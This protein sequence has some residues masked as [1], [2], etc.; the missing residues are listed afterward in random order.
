MLKFLFCDFISVPI[1]KLTNC[2]FFLSFCTSVCCFLSLAVPHI[3]HLGLHRLMPPLP[4]PACRSPPASPTGLRRRCKENG[5]PRPGVELAR[6]PWCQRGAPPRT[7]PAARG[8]RAQG[9]VMWLSATSRARRAE[10]AHLF[11]LLPAAPW[12]LPLSPGWQRWLPVLPQPVRGRPPAPRACSIISPSARLP[13]ALL[14]LHLLLPALRLL[15]SAPMPSLSPSLWL[16][17]S[18]TWSP[19][20]P[21]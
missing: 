19:R 11:F 9:T 12:V 14:P 20:R 8:S 10:G 3:S 7:T 4:H 2:S 6:E 1:R 21:P 5:Q 18:A 15:L 17:A 16:C 13:R